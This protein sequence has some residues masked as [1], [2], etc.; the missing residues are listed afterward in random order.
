MP[1]Q[2]LKCQI[3]EE[4]DSSLYQ[5][6][7]EE[8]FAFYCKCSSWH[9]T[10]MRY[11]VVG[12]RWLIE[13]FP[14]S[15]KRIVSEVGVAY[16]PYAKADFAYMIRGKGSQLKEILR[17]GSTPMG[18]NLFR[19]ADPCVFLDDPVE[20]VNAHDFIMGITPD[21][22]YGEYPIIEVNS[23]VDCED[24]VLD[25]HREDQAFYWSLSLSPKI[26]DLMIQNES[27]IEIFNPPREIKEEVF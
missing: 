3:I 11:T 21:I 27:S 19:E 7:D 10:K 26:L 16:N 12:D 25:F 6:Q 22:E 23:Y 24:L 14:L 20:I 13:V 2:P 15:N 9:S 8:L 5:P 17:I 1:K 4:V 18:R